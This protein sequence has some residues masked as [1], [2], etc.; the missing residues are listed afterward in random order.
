MSKSCPK[1]YETV[2]KKEKLLVKSNFSFFPQY[3]QKTCTSDQGLFGKGLRWPF[4]SWDK[5][6]TKMLKTFTKMLKNQPY[7]PKAF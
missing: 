7:T 6:F 1:G 4:R 2:G 3:F 5:T